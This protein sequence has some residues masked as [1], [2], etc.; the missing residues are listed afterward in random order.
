MTTSGSYDYNITG[1]NIILETLELIG[2]A[3]TGFTVS[4]EDQKTV[5]RTFN[6]F[7]KWL[8]SKG[9]GLWKNV[10]I[11]LFPSY[12][13]YSYDIGPTGDHCS[14][15]AY[16]TE[17]ATA[18]SS[19]ASSI[20]VDSDDNMTDGDY[21]GIELDDGTLQWTTINGS[22]SSN[23]VTLTAALTDDVAVNNHVYNYTSK[24]QR[25]TEIVEVRRVNADGTENPIEIYSRQE[26]MSLSQKTSK[27]AP[28]SIYYDPLLTNGKMWVWNACGDVQQYI[29]FTGRIMI[30]DFDSA[31]D[32][33]D[34]PQE[35]TLALCYTLAR[36]VAP[37]FGRVLDPDF[38]LMQ[39]EL[40]DSVFG[41]D[42]EDTS[43]FIGAR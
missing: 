40:F 32:D 4:S 30:E 8:Q 33:P 12:E 11:S 29:K 14:T 18:A 7:V 27:G 22:P 3:G 41:F 36:L 20:V 24:T 10:E 38:K 37:K 42:M 35:W 23:T 13:G 6:L 26:Y 34:F 39:S 5:L 19:G 16:K 28:I 15:N 25:P 31:T 9:V 43:I 21:I 2:V 17:I 1:Q